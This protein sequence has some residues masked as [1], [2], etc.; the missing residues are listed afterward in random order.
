MKPS[1]STRLIVS[2]LTFI[3]R[4]SVLGCREV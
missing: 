2:E 1:G 4:N 3:L